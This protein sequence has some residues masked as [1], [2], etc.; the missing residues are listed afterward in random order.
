MMKD[1]THGVLLWRLSTSDKFET[2]FDQLLRDLLNAPLFVKPP[3]GSAPVLAATEAAKPTQPPPVTQLMLVLA[4]IYGNSSSNGALR[5]EYASAT[6][7]TSKLFFDHA[8]DQAIR[9]GFVTSQGTKQLIWVTEK[10]RQEMI[11]LANH[12]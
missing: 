11:N 9:S 5:T 1:K 8:L 6:M 10:G 3:L 7:G 12:S 2:G 4:K